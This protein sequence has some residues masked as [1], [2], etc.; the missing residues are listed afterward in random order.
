MSDGM[1]DKA[2]HILE[3]LRDGDGPMTGAVIAERLLLEG[4]EVSERT[5]RLY[6]GLL[7]K[8]G[9]ARRMGRKGCL[10]TEDGRTEL[11]GRHVFERV[12]FLSAKIDQMTYAMDFDLDRR[13]GSVVVN[14]VTVM[15]EMLRACID[16]ITQVFKCGYA[17]GELTALLP[18]GQHGENV[19]IPEGLVGFT[20][21][22]SVTLNGVLLKHGIP[23]AS[24][25]G[26]L[27]E[28]RNGKPRRFVEIIMYDGTS[29]D[30][31][32]VFIRSGMTNYIGAIR[33][34]NGQIGASFREIPANSREL[35]VALSHK[36][37]AIGL[38]AILEIGACGK[39]LLE[40]PISEG[41]AGMILIGGLNPA[42]VFQEK[43]L[44]YSA[45]VMSGLLE[46]NRLIHYSQL[47][48][49]VAAL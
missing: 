45:Q 41:R 49:Q 1:P 19:I 7:E 46:F 20:T 13:A 31:L 10:I 43:D 30:P 16:E 36:L 35:A 8:E 24:R 44:P 22:C 5:I 12:G 14:T 18:P 39:P 38:G 9:L 48:D 27:I 25:F 3:V 40:I 42:S 34:G 29:V 33:N 6:L 17:M 21:V 23:M 26:G 15:P 32:E 2:W 47:K 28:L 37:K 11:V 4:R